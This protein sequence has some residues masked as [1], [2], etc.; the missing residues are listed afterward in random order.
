MPGQITKA[1]AQAALAAV[2]TQFAAYFADGDIPGPKLYPPGFH[3]RS[4]TIAWEEGPYEWALLA[5]HG[6]FD[7]EIYALVLPEAGPEAARRMATKPG[8][9]HPDGVDSEPV[10]SWCLA[11]YPTD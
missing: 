10:N 5:F 3:D 11:L 2:R 6:G 4:W 8:V 9:A 7:E 1:Q